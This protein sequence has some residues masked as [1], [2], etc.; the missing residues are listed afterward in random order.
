M[1]ASGLIV[2][3]V[4]MYDDPHDHTLPRKVITYHETKQKIKRLTLQ[5]K[6]WLCKT[7]TPPRSSR[8]RGTCVPAVSHVPKSQSRCEPKLKVGTWVGTEQIESKSS[9]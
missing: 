7:T 3:C 1:S 4:C 6:G 2:H 8:S 9:M 5:W